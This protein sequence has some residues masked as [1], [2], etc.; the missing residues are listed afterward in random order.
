MDL[1]EAVLPDCLVC[2]NEWA[3]P[4]GL[5]AFSAREPAA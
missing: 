3:A 2:H 5:V 4:A 1:Q